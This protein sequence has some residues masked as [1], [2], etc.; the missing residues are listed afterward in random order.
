MININ[1]STNILQSRSACITNIR[2]FVF[3][4][5]TGTTHR[6]LT[7]I[8][9]EV[10]LTRTGSYRNMPRKVASITGTDLQTLASTSK[11]DCVASA[12]VTNTVARRLCCPTNDINI[13]PPSFGCI[14]DIATCPSPE[15]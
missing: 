12:L 15:K 7:A 4:G 6:Q 10:P 14:T 8:T 13:N 5:S 1:T 3:A 9:P 2:L 11:L